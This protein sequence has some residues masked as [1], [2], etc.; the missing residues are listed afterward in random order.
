[1]KYDLKEILAY[2]R[3]NPG[4][5][6]FMLLVIIGGMAAGAVAVRFMDE[7]PLTEVSSAIHSYFNELKE[8]EGLFFT[9]AELLRSSFYKNGSIL[10]LI[11]ILGL[12]AGGFALV[13]PIVFL[14][15][16]SLGFT[17][18]VV[19]YR[20]SLKG[21]LFCLAAI[22]PHNLFF[23]PVYMAAAIFAFAHSLYLYK[24]RHHRISMFEHPFIRQYCLYMTIILVAAIAGVLVEAYITPVF[25]RLVLPL[26]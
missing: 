7:G 6:I 3:E 11:W 26:I 1:M 17:A 13:L 8:D 15:G 9:P 16:F 23:V 12:Y 24:N 18:S 4:I 25:I 14:K 2:F 20:Y 19:F 5:F 21:A 22:L 10:L